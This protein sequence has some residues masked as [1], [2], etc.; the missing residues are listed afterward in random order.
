MMKKWSSTRLEKMGSAIFSE[1]AEWKQEALRSGKKIIDLGIG[2]P[3]LPPSAAVI[4]RMKESVSHPELYGYPSSE[5]TMRLRRTVKQWLQYRFGIEVNPE[6][7]IITLMGSQDGLAHLALATTNPGDVALIPD[8]GYPIYQ[9]SL[10]LAGVEGY[11]LPLRAE[12]QYLPKFEEIP[13]SILKKAKLMVLNYPSNPVA[14]VA[15]RDFYERALQFAKDNDLFIVHDMAYSELAFDGFR[16][17]S[18]L[19]IDGAKEYVV[20][21][22][23][24]SKG[25]NMAGCRIAFM[26]GC[27]EVV[28]ALKIVKSNI[29]YGVFLPIQLAAEE[30]LKQDMRKPNEIITVYQRR[31][32]VLVD[33]L[34]KI[35]FQVHKPRATM[36]I[37]AKIPEGWTSRHISRE[38]LL[39]AG[40]AV[41]PGDAFGKEGEGYVRAALVQ[42][43]TF[44]AE[45]VERIDRFL[46]KSEARKQ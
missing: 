28:R 10:V 4:N 39:N 6:S 8:P 34:R 44:L 35:G 18:M 42:D 37:W 23:S 26:I 45:A 5:G 17:M 41:I 27:E 24:M 20:E 15:E 1:V 7:E 19:E 3:D 38:I 32:D 46:K 16:P 33:G 25:F 36:F 11:S 12:N 13:H 29:D 9:G 31:R 14:A 22:H 43:E 40:V 2:S 21:M 30:A